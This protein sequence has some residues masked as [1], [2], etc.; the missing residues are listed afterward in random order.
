MFNEGDIVKIVDTNKIE[1]DETLEKEA[2]QII[3]KSNYTG[4]VTKVEDGI[5]FVGFMNDLG[6][7]TQGFKADEIQEVK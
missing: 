5:H 4:E 1:S 2:L 3:K 7:V 6:W